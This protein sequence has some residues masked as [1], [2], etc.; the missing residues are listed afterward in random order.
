MRVSMIAF[1]WFISIQPLWRWFLCRWFSW[2]LF[3]C[4]NKRCRARGTRRRRGREEERE[5]KITSA[6]ASV[7]WKSKTAICAK[8]RVMQML[9]L[10]QLSMQQLNPN[11][12]SY[13]KTSTL[14]SI[15]LQEWSVSAKRNTKRAKTK[16]KILF[17]SFTTHKW[18]RTHGKRRQR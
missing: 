9:V 1:Y 3:L 7:T 17:K 14:P 2:R 10:F 8:E 18:Q 12:N 5:K 13:W 4:H 15:H 16:T 11:L 6:L